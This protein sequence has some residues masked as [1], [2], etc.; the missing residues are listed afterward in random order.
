M[1]LRAVIGGDQN[2]INK[3]QLAFAGLSLDA[4]TARVA[5]FC[6]A[7]LTFDCG[8]H[9][10]SPLPIPA[11]PLLHICATSHSFIFE[12]HSF[13]RYQPLNIPICPVSYPLHISSQKYFEAANMQFAKL[14]AIGSPLVFAALAQ[15]KIAFTTLPGSV[16]AGV[17]TVLTWTGG[18]PGEVSLNRVAYLPSH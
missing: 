18:D 3:D 15:A 10:N 2:N 9:Q 8:E 5:P 4:S 11:F 13:S 12:S 1:G 16:Q 17:P 6:H 14:L 7:Q